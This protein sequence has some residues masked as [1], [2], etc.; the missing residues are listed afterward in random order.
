MGNGDG[1]YPFIAKFRE[2]AS[3]SRNQK[4]ALLRGFR[5]ARPRLELGTPRF[6]GTE[7]MVVLRCENPANRRSDEYDQYRLDPRK[8]HAF[9]CDSGSGVRHVAQSG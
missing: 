2:A 9:R 8:F 5:M 4:T 7:P 6:S 3:Q 1:H